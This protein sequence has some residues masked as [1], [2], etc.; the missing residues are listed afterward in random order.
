MD[1]TVLITGFLLFFILAFFGLLIWLV[2]F[3]PFNNKFISLSMVL[4]F[5]AFPILYFIFSKEIINKIQLLL[6]YC[7]A[8][9]IGLVISP[10]FVFLITFLISFESELSLIHPIFPPLVEVSDIL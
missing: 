1:K 6:G 8:I 2:F 7:I 5:L 3:N 9:F 10:I 4:I